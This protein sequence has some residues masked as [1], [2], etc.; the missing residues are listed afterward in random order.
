MRIEIVKNQTGKSKFNIV[1]FQKRAQVV[2]DTEV[3]KQKARA[4]SSKTKD[5]KETIKCNNPL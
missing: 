4:L 5:C 2:F 3:K 1:E